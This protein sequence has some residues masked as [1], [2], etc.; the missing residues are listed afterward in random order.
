MDRLEASF[1]VMG[2]SCSVTQ[3]LMARELMNVFAGNELVLGAFFVSWLLGI[4]LGSRMLGRLT[5]RLTQRLEWFAATLTVIAVVVP[6]QILFVRSLSGW[7]TPLKG[8]VAGLPS[9]FISTFLVLLPFCALYGLQFAL[10]CSLHIGGEAPATRI[11]RVYILEALGAVA[12]GLAFTYILVH[13]LRVLQIGVF[14]GLINLVM[15]LALLVQRRDP[16]PHPISRRAL[17]IVVVLLIVGAG[18]AT[19]IGGLSDLERASAGWQWEGLGLIHSENTVHGNIAVTIA[20]DQRDFWV[21]GLPVFTVPHPDTVYVEET[22]HIPMLLHPAPVDVL[23]IGGGV[24]GALEELLKHPVSS[25]TYVEL[26]PKMIELTRRFAPEASRILDDPRMVTRYMDGRLFVKRA[27]SEYDMV[28]VSL[29]PPSTL[30]LN[31]FYTVEFFREIREL[32]RPDGLLSLTLSSSPSAIIEEMA[33]RNRCVYEALARSFPSVL[34]VAGEYNIFVASQQVDQ[35]AVPYIDVLYSR[36]VQRELDLGLLTEEY[37]AYKFSPLR[38]EA[39]LDYLGEGRSEA[40][41]DLRPVAVF[42]DLALWNAMY[43]HLTRAFLG[44]LSDL[45]LRLLSL[46][47]VGLIFYAL[48]IRERLRGSRRPVYAALITTG[49]GGMV[50]SVVNIYAFQALCGYLYQEL[51]VISAAYMLGSALG[52]GLMSGYTSKKGGG[53]HILY[54][55]ELA[56]A[57][58]SVLLP[59]VLG[60]LFRLGG[61]GSSFLLS[62]FALPFLNCAAGFLVSLEFPLASDVVVEG[63]LSVGSTAGALY[64]SDLSGACVGALLSS[65][66]LIPLH[67][68][69]G[70]CLV[71]AALNL[72]SLMVLYVSKGN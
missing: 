71:V 30:Q 50:F 70:A 36:S 28:V 23:V 33:D 67:G 46:P 19:L 7:I 40:N 3:V 58:F 9:T 43:G 1:V 45:E 8:E 15:V 69:L 55:T 31:R 39:G 12:G 37:L 64:A 51:G 56:V 52:A 54:R 60:Y 18:A 57:A 11:S 61:G 47:L 4:A 34:A 59:V 26:D 62:R 13:R 22:I 38:M 27:A 20:L 41:S 72:S 35:A 68:V 65:I 2:F 17:T 6:L 24:G 63:D 16:T 10:G 14:L 5:D 32:L 25:V 66:W 29:P 53:R 49:L 48:T 42:H 44:L 21:N